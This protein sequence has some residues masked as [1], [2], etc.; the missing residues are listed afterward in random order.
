MPTHNGVENDLCLLKSAVSLKQSYFH[1]LCTKLRRY[2]IEILLC[3]Y[4]YMVAYISRRDKL[5]AAN[6]ACLCPE[7]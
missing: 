5:L 1:S 3:M 2:I 4:I 6:V 7:T